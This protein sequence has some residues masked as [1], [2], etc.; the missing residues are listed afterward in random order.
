MYSVVR[1]SRTKPAPRAEDLSFFV[2][3]AGVDVPAFVHTGIPT[4]HA[5]GGIYLREQQYQ[6]QL[7]IA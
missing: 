5:K 1:G 3:V 7:R 2:R 6:R 4:S